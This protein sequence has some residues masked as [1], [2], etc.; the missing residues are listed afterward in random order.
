MSEH[1]TQITVCALQCASQLPKPHALLSLERS[2]ART[3]PHT[4]YHADLQ[5]DRRGVCHALIQMFGA[6]EIP[7]EGLA[8]EVRWRR[9]ELGKPYVAFEGKVAEW[10]ESRG[11]HT[12]HLHVSNTHDGQR[13]LLLT[14][15]APNVVGCGIDVV[16]TP[17]LSRPSQ[18]R[19]FLQHFARKFMSSTEHEAIQVQLET[20][21]IE[22]L[23]LRVAAHF[24]LMEAASKACGT[25]LKVGLGMGT[26]S[27]LP[28]QSLG[29]RTL[30]PQVELLIE[31]Q[32][33]TRLET[34]GATRS[35][36][37]WQLLDEYLVS[38]V[39]LFR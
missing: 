35:F 13:Q 20:E 37:A 31:G 14:L 1:D 36:A 6:E 5:R 33:L 22:R 21:E 2:T 7:Q 34:M 39:L 38:L 26:P 24:S 10:A 23:R 3:D 30:S 27:S 15:Y 28:M 8:Q 32:A 25:G 9:D 29:V 4:R 16:Y 17:R 11:L 19:A 18:D 12:Q